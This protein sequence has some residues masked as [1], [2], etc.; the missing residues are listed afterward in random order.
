MY[1]WGIVALLIVF[2]PQYTLFAQQVDMS[3]FKTMKARSVGPAGMSGRITAIDAVDNNPTIMYAGSASGGLWKSTSGGITWTP[4]FD[5]EKVHSIG[6][7][8]S[9]KEPHLGRNRRRQPRNS[10]I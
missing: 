10:S 7:I 2:S 1:L 4:I 3:Q 6:A 8:S 9:T 5:E